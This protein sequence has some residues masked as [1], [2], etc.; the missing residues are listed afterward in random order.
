MSL[1][2]SGVRKFFYSKE[3]LKQIDFNIKEEEFVCILGHSG[4]GKSTLLNMIA[5]FLTPDEG[6]IY[7]NENRV[8]GPAKERGVVF[9]EHA[10]FP[11]FTVRENIAFGPTIQKEN[12][13]KVNEKV[14][15]YLKLVGLVEF[16]DHYPSQLSGGMKQRVGIARA[17]ANEP[18]VLLM[19]EPFGAL[20]I[21]T[22][23]TMRRELTRIWSE[24]KPI[25][26]FVTHSISEAIHLGDRILVMKEGQVAA[27]YKVNMDRPRD[28]RDPEFTRLTE[29]L[30]TILMEEKQNEYSQIS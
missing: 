7:V 15:Y 17:L 4:C 26:I 19:D 11:W 1:Q 9:Q 27:D 2:V 20:D 6:E 16:A 29:E 12:K 30:E 8:K 3:V 10:L 23:E 24:L 22:R 18:E 14:D 13:T 25:V 5:G 28:Q 21:L